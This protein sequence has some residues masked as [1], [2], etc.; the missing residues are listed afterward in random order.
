VKQQDFEIKRASIFDMNK[1]VKMAFFHHKNDPKFREICSNPLKSFLYRLFGPL[2]VR[3]TLISFKAV[4]CGKI[5]GYVLVKKRDHSIHIWDLVVNSEFR[6]KGIGSNLMQYAERIAEDRQRYVT[7]AVMENNIPAIRL[8]SGLGYENLQFSPVCY[9]VAK[10][11][12]PQKDSKFTELEPISKKGE[13]IRIRCDNYATV[14][15]KVVGPAKRETALLLYPL[16]SKMRRKTEYFRIFTSAQVGYLSVRRRKD[17]TSIFL[18]VNPKVWET[19]A[20]TEAITKVIEKGCLKSDQFE[21]CVVQ[22]YEEYLQKAFI[23]AECIAERE[24]PRLVLV[25]KLD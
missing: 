11:K 4:A 20:E 24:T 14:L 21:I 19:D 1:I 12:A 2:Y 23:K 25:K 6:G 22:A 9:L 3:L 18:L 15:D 16:P 17:L 8:Y 5:A 13:V 7:L 10:P